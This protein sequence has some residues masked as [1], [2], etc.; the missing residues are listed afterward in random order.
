[1]VDILSRLDDPCSSVR[2]LAIECLSKI[3][4]DHSDSNFSE[5]SYSAL[6]KTVISRLFLYFDDPFIKLRPILLGMKTN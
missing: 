3:D 1:M 6:A 5:T 2:A 4:V